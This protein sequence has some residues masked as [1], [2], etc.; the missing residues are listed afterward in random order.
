MI[1]QRPPNV[2]IASVWQ[3]ARVPGGHGAGQLG[4]LQ[5]ALNQPSSMFA[6]FSIANGSFGSMAILHSQPGAAGTR[7]A[8]CALDNRGLHATCN[9]NSAA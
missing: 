9:S 3:T 5:P 1:A 8:H 2:L 6:R 7:P 4:M